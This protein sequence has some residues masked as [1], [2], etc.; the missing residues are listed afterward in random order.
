MFWYKKGVV[1]CTG[2]HCNELPAAYLSEK[3]KAF[4]INKAATVA[5]T[6]KDYNEEGKGL[7]ITKKSFFED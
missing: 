4:W 5:I 7:I 1:K 6:P 2:L 3:F